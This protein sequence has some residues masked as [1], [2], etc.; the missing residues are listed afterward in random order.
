MPMAQA[1]KEVPTELEQALDEVGETVEVKAGRRVVSV[2][3]KPFRLRQFS[4]VLKCVQRLRD[5]GVI[6][7][8]AIRGVAAAENAEEA[9]RG[10]DMVKMFLD[11]GDE[12]VNILQIAVGRGQQLTAAAVDDLDLVDGARL[13]SAVF[14]VNLDFFY[15]NREAIQGALAPALKA[16]D[17]VV[18]EGVDAL[19]QPPSTD[20]EGQGTA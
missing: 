10:F 9:A 5:C 14:A 12:I 20:F 11:G 16:V 17:T 3:V 15:R 13:A 18:S 1:L 2:T 6:E 19:G 8:K 7:E 4:Q